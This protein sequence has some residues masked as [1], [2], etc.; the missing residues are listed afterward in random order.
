MRRAACVVVAIAAVFV[1]PVASAQVDLTG[2]WAA[3]FNE[4]QLERVPGPALGDYLGLPITDEARAFAALPGAERAVRL[5]LWDD[6]A[7][8]AGRLTPPL[9]HFVPIMQSAAKRADA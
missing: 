1:P 5:R 8:T 7:K 2:N 6:S 3:V 9:A 4:D